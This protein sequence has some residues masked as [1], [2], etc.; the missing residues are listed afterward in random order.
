MPAQNQFGNRVRYS[1]ER[2]D[3]GLNTKDAPSKISPYESPDCLNVVFDK[4]GSAE[5]RDGS[6]TFNTQAIGGFSIDGMYSYNQTMV[7]WAGGSMYR[8]SGTTFVTIPSAQ[9]QFTSGRKV[10]AQAYQGILFCSDG[11]LG[12]W[13]YHAGDSF[14]NMGLVTPSAPTG[15]SNGAGSLATGTYYYAISFVNTQAVEGE[16]GSVSAGIAITNSATIQVKSIPVGGSLAGVAKRR[17]YRS[18]ATTGPFRFVGEV[19]DNTTTVFNDTIANDQE[20]QNAILDAP[21]PTAFNTISL[22]MERL[23]FDDITNNSLLRWTDYTNP[24]VSDSTNFEPI[25]NKDGDN[26]VAIISNDDVLTIFKDNSHFF[27]TMTDPSDDLTWAL[28]KG[29]TNLGIVGPRALC[30]IQNGVLF[31]GKQNYRLTGFHWLTGLTIL[32]STDGKLR[33]VALSEKIER[34]LINYPS[35]YWNN[36]ALTSYKNKAYTTITAGAADTTNKNLLWFDLNRVGSEGQPGSWALWDGLQLNQTIVHNGLLYGGSSAT[37]GFIYQLEAGVSSDS[38][39]AIN[40][41]FWTKKIG[42]DDINF[43]LDGFIKDFREIFLWHQKLGN[44]NMNV[45]WRIDGDT[46]SG[47]G[48]I[49]NLNNT[50]SLWD[51]LIWDSGVWDGA[52]DDVVQRLP[53][54]KLLG[55]TIQIRFDNQNVAGQKFKVHRIELGMNVRRHR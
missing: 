19:A 51:T 52:R 27:L 35:A 9:G 10:A 12:P 47:N 4:E 23:F 17:V 43:S 31:V 16:V 14:Y 1:I 33:S 41:Y 30:R 48:Q 29:S 42:G 34:D 5:T 3:G 37:N 20:G 13:R 44:F 50:A 25:S 11:V 8:A 26:I 49:I 36:I 15:A 28:K 38:G 55:K 53:I 39:A 32:Q 21:P 40:S 46:G 18:S 54:G 22:H 6:V 45:K 2:F 24:F 7:A